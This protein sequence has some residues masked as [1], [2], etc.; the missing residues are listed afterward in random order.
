M[1][2]PGPHWSPA[3]AECRQRISGL[4]RSVRLPRCALRPREVAELT[5][6]L[7][8][9]EKELNDAMNKRNEFERKLKDLQKDYDKV[10]SG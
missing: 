7:A 6:Q 5:E 8:T 9:K 2:F 4:G 10:K 1:A 3:C